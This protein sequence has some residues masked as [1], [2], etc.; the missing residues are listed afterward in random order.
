MSDDTI[1]LTSTA[2]IDDSSAMTAF[3]APIPDS[4]VLAELLSAKQPLNTRAYDDER[5]AARFV[6]SDGTTATC[7]AVT[8]ITIDQAEMITLE[9]EETDAW[10]D[11]AF[12]AAADRILSRTL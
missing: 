7:F 3:L 2:R 4:E 8:G 1:I 5:Q 12:R 10:S 9:C 6:I 11:A